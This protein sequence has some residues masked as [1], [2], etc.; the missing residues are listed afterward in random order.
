MSTSTVRYEVAGEGIATITLDRPDV[1]NA[2]SQQMRGEL[3]AA[4]R[5]ADADDAVR[6]IMLRGA[7]DR[8]FCTGLDVRE[9]VPPASLV[10]ARQDRAGPIWNDLIS[11]ARKPTLAA[12]HGY[13]LGGGLEIALACDV[14]IA[15]ADAA[16]GFPEVR[17]GIIPG[18]GGTQRLPRLVGRGQ[19][20]RLILTGERIDA[21]EALRIGLVTEVVPGPELAGRA[22]ACATQLSRGAPRA[23]EYAKEAIMRGSELGLADGLRLESDLA[24][25]LMS[26]EDRVE[27]AAAFADRR[28]PHF[29]GH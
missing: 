6:A 3:S 1:L 4:V 5:A 2:I 10:E 23:I 17:L 21:A 19:A 28:A 26:T 16:F 11:A 27:G 24:T 29:T 15:S 9:F 18:A 22:S 20:L 14:R 12:V 7:G 25:L 8:A 13:C